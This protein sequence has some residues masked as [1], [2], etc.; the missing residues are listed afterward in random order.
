MKIA[1]IAELNKGFLVIFEDGS[2]LKLSEEVYFTCS[3]YEKEELS[4]EEAEELLFRE[5]V[6]DGLI[7]CKR[8]IAGGLKPERRLFAYMEDKGL[9]K[10]VADEIIRILYDEEYIDDM[11]YAKK[12][13]KRKMISSPVSSSML[14]DYLEKDGV[15]RETAEA[16]VKETGIDDHSVAARLAEKKLKATK[17]NKR[18]TAQ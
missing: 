16:A 4:E 11:K 18:K 5:Q 14:V 12:R 13:I 17:G 15:G 3:V 10:A 8:Y 1:R 2:E 7:M 6:T 9:E